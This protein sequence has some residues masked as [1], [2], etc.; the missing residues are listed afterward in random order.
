MDAA[1]EAVTAAARQLHHRELADQNGT[2]LLEL[3]Q[4]GG[5]VIEDLAGV[6][7]RAPGG[8]LAGVA[9]QILCAER[10]ALQRAAV[11]L[12]LQLFVH[13]AGAADGGLGE[14]QRERIVARP[15]LLQP[16]GEGA[17]QLVYG[18]F[19]G[20]EF[21]VQLTDGREEDIVREFGHYALKENAGSVDMGSLSFAERFRILPELLLGCGSGDLRAAGASGLGCANRTLPTQR[22]PPPNACA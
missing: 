11:A 2:G 9:Q 4:N 12:A 22:R 3:L 5:G 16:L 6:R 19:L 1:G 7:A 14:R 8:E 18:E 10:N 21:G 15:Q 20:P 13:V 17:H